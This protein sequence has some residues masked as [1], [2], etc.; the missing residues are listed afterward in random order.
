MEHI[1]Q[2]FI[3]HAKIFVFTLCAK[4]IHQTL[5]QDNKIQW[6]GRKEE[7]KWRDYLESYYNNP[8]FKNDVWF[9]VMAV[10]NGIST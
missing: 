6:I 1:T 5:E 4:G 7:K 2:G 3:S 10:D 8:S 9:R